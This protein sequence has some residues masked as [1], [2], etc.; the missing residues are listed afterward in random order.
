MI[1]KKNIGKKIKQFRTNLRKKLDLIR[2]I[3]T[4]KKTIERLEENLLKEKV[5]CQRLY[6]KL[7]IDKWEIRSYKLQIQVIEKYLKKNPNEDLQKI[8]DEVKL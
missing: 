1:N 2:I 3:L 5:K 7:N 8:I 6:D 4:K